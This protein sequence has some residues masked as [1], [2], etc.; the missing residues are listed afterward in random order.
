MELLTVKDVATILQISEDAVSRRFTGLDGVINLG[1]KTLGKRHYNVLRI[2]RSV[3][4]RYLSVRAGKTVTVTVPEHADRRRRS[5]N[6]E[7]RAIL[8]LAK[9]ARMNGIDGKDNCADAQKGSQ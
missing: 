5:P 8:N 4:E 9:A 6:W 1:K 3:L 7:K 2:P